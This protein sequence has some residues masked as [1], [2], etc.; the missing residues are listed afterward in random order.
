MSVVATAVIA[1]IEATAA[2]ASRRGG[3]AVLPPPQELPVLRRQCAEDRLQ[4]CQAPAAVR[5]G[6]R[7]DRSKPHH[8]RLGKETARA[9][10]S[11]QA[12][13]VSRAAALRD[14]L[15]EERSTWK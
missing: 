3:P 4:G 2:T 5:I 11:D 8:R 7:Q 13:A 9:R 10:A 15:S 1:S 14:P 12:R 6:T